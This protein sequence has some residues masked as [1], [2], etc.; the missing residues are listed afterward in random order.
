MVAVRGL[1]LIQARLQLK[2]TGYAVEVQPALVHWVGEQR[3]IRVAEQMRR[4]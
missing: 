2:A 4:V 1:R 3:V